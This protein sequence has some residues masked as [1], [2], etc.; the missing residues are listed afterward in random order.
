VT[1]ERTQIRNVQSA[2]QNKEDCDQINHDAGLDTRSTMEPELSLFSS[3]IRRSTPRIVPI[4]IV[5]MTITVVVWAS[6]ACWVQILGADC[7]RADRADF[8]RQPLARRRAQ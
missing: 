7:K 8:R 1:D 3:A 6:L 2:V 4:V 5:R